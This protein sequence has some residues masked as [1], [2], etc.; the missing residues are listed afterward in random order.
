MWPNPLPGGI[1]TTPFACGRPRALERGPSIMSGTGVSS[2]VLSGQIGHADPLAPVS[3][4]AHLIQNHSP[5][6]P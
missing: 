4:S 3:M 1:G 6:W 5:T 2:L